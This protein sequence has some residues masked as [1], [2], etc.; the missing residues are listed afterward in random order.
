MTSLPLSVEP[1]DDRPRCGWVKNDPLLIQ[2]HDESWGV[3]PEDDDEAFEALT[4]EIFQ[5]GLSWRTVLAKRGAFRRS[6]AGFQAAEVALFDSGDVARLA[7]DAGII[8]NRQKIE[9]TIAN[10]REVLAIQRDADTFLGWLNQLPADPE[11]A[12]IVL[13]PRFRFF[14]RTTCESFL[15]AIGKIPIQHDPGCWKANRTGDN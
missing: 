8:R 11:A 10:A 9:A 5:A 2:Y 13:R 15:E 6:F 1:I 3:P 12:F 14:G 7:L 4:L